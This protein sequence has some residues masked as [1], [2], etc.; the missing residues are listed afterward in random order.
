VGTTRRIIGESLSADRQT[1]LVDEYIA[2]GI[3]EA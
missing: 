1:A 2:T 3:A